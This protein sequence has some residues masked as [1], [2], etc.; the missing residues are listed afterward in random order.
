MSHHSD[1]NATCYGEF[2]I[3]KIAK[4]EMIK[5][6]EYVYKYLNNRGDTVYV[7]ITNDMNRRVKEHKTD[8]LG[9]IKNPLIYYFPVK[10]RG[11][12]EMLETYLIGWY[13][14]KKYYNVAKTEKGDFSF[15]DVIEDFPWKPYTGDPTAE[16]KPF[17]ISEVI[18]TKEIIVEKEKIIEKK[19]PIRNEAVEWQLASIK[20]D[21]VKETLS[22][23]E[24]E[25]KENIEMLLRLRS[26]D[27]DTIDHELV[28]EGLELFMRRSRIIA[29][30]KKLYKYGYLPSTMVPVPCDIY[31]KRRKRWKRTIIL[32]EKM[33][34]KIKHHL[35]ACGA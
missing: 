24:K 6:V 7:G 30:Q 27:D 13:G 19:V 29:V 3:E 18:G 34:S 16:E 33:S 17:M 23:L 2:A 25:T 28:D 11:D 32:A 4:R 31:R 21:R 15:L 9:E 1:R 5:S 10:Y 12:A 14:T 35:D 26:S 8:K 20:A 22:N